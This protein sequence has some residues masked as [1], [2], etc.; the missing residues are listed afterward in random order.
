MV[1]ELRE[2]REK[3][4]KKKGGHSRTPRKGFTNALS[5]YANREG[6][7]AIWFATCVVSG[8]GGLSVLP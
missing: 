1:R 7:N 4:Y 2:I 8:L 5:R 6:E 3:K